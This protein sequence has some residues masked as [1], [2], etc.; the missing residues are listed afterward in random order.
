M[1]L[2]LAETTKSV[3]NTVKPSS[4]NDKTHSG[5]FEYAIWIK[6]TR[7][8]AEIT[9]RHGL[10]PQ[11]TKKMKSLVGELNNFHL[12]RTA[13]TE[14]IKA[15]VKTHVKDMFSPRAQLLT[16]LGH[17]SLGQPS[18]FNNKLLPLSGIQMGFH[19][20]KIKQAKKN[21]HDCIL[22]GGKYHPY[23]DVAFVRSLAASSAPLSGSSRPVGF[24]VVLKRMGRDGR[25]GRTS[26]D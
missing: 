7:D 10:F 11:P 15:K 9:K 16:T 24:G 26:A 19:A 1:Y 12:H 14:I 20:Y 8:S 6:L 23:D 21:K 25:D 17:R 3:V 4:K 2:C 5:Q 18:M 22:T 13:S